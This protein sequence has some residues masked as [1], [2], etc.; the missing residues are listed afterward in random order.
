MT[1]RELRAWEA[2]G[3]ATTQHG[4]T[5]TF[6]LKEALYKAQYPLTERWL[7][8][9]HIEVEPTRASHSFRAA[10]SETPTSPLGP[11][12][13]RPLGGRCRILEDHVLS[14]VVLQHHPQST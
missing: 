9:D 13:R 6:S 5:A 1:E 4:A 12:V 11:M 8:F 14:A 7:G 10:F 2:F 3:P